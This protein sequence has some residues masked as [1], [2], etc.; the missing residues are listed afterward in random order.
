MGQCCN[1]QTNQTGIA[2][3][4][5]YEELDDMEQLELLEYFFVLRIFVDLSSM[6]LHEKVQRLSFSV[7]YGD[8]FSKDWME[9]IKSHKNDEY[10][11]KAFKISL[12]QHHAT[13][14]ISIQV[15]TI[16]HNKVKIE[17]ISEDFSFMKLAVSGGTA[18]H[19]NL[20]ESPLKIQ[21]FEDL[22]NL[23]DVEAQYTYRLEIEYNTSTIP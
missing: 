11:S 4:S 14:P 5:K 13:L 22:Q 21:M 2:H 10:V 7:R 6:K 9:D 1:N 19:G 8:K 20:P 3:S 18:I 17:S 23:E 16:G 12:D 15:C